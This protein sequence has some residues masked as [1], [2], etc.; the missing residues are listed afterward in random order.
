MPVGPDPRAGEIADL[1]ERDEPELPLALGV[2][3]RQVR[4]ALGAVGAPPSVQKV[5]KDGTA[6]PVA[7]PCRS[8]RHPDGGALAS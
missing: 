4:Q 3:V 8:R 2:F 5:G 7:A 6:P 1:L